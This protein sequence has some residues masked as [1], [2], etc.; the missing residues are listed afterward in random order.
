VTEDIQVRSGPFT[1]VLTGGAL[2][3]IRL[4]GYRALDAV[5]VAVRDRDWNTIPG[6]I[7]DF[8]YVPRPGGFAASWYSRHHRG[9]VD[10]GWQGRVEADQQEISFRVDGTA[11][12]E[13]DTNRIGVCLLHP[14]ELT[15]TEIEVA[16]ADGST[17]TAS[18]PY[19][20]SPRPVVTGA[21]G[22]S[23]E[24]G[25]GA[26][27]GLRLDGGLLETEDHRNWTDPG[28]KTYTPPLSE[29][30]PRRMRPG[31]RISQV[32]TLTGST[33]A[34][35][36]PPPP[37]T[38]PDGETV[39]LRLGSAAGVLPALG[40][41]LAAGGE[42]ELESLRRMRPALLHVELR[43]VDDVPTRLDLAADQAA[44]IGSKLSVALIG[45]DRGWL[46]NCGR[47]LSALRLPIAAVGVFEPPTGI[48][49]PRAAG[50]VRRE[51]H[52]GHPGTPVGGGSML[53]FAELNRAASRDPDWDFAAFPVTAQA[54]HTDDSLVMS[55]VLGQRAAVRDASA[56]TGG[57]PVVVGPAS[58]RARRTPTCPG[59]PGDPRDPRESE[60]M[61]AA[62]LCASVA[63]MHAAGMIMF[64]NPL[65]DASG[66]VSEQAGIESVAARLAGLAGQPIAEVDGDP[67]RVAALA[68]RRPGRAPL[69]MAANLSPHPVRVRL[70]QRAWSLEG[71]G[72][73]IVEV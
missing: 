19:H 40:M 39:E 31:D 47:G 59:R 25:P 23:Y 4:L 26:R 71:Y 72:T 73:A 27:L 70:D 28:W 53:H 52:C 7:S 13:F 42:P 1:S 41:V 65:V 45:P 56:L 29:S 20:V 50:L 3:D 61:G 6:V 32:V 14:A 34:S 36:A 18:F 17:G 63:A 68:V 10:F 58:L 16:F 15:G 66:V 30:G 43:E 57:R 38:E 54:H 55:T 37:E 33:A 64:L 62:W 11:L 51:L 35:A 9:D 67:R 22:L 5:H 8:Q 21:A 24:T 12:G 44:Q 69:L 2:R 46:A 48:A 49:A 60:P